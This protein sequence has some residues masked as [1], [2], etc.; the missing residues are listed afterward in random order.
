MSDYSSDDDIILLVMKRKRLHIFSSFEDVSDENI[1][2]GSE[3]DCYESDDTYSEDNES[4]KENQ[5]TNVWKSTGCNRKPF[6]FLA[7][8]GQHEIVPGR[9]RF[10]CS[11]YIEKYILKSPELKTAIKDEKMVFNK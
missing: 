5:D 7:N 9:F 3:T 8:H 11:F 6:E 4:D 10:K 1:E 2:S